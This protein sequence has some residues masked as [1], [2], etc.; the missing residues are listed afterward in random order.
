MVNLFIPRTYLSKAVLG[1]TIVWCAFDASG[2]LYKDITVTERELTS[3]DNFQ[4]YL[5][6]VNASTQAEILQ[7]F[8]K[9]IVKEPELEVKESTFPSAE[10]QAKQNGE[11]DYFFADD[12]QI[13]LAA[14]VSDVIGGKQQLVALMS[15]KDANGASK[16]EYIKSDVQLFGYQFSIKNQYQVELEKKHSSHSQNIVLTM[17]QQKHKS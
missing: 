1:I 5:P 17:Y 12:K 9:Y 10:E 4:S 2:R 15:I 11:L 7:K 6:L 13:S 16:I 3:Y 8:A 14:I